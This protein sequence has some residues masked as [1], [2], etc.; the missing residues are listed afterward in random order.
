MRES[1]LSDEDLARM[2]A[3]PQMS[4]ECRLRAGSNADCE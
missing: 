2:R 4:V 3:A 1:G